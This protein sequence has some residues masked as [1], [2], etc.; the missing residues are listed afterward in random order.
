[1]VFKF[2]M[3]MILKKKKN[4]LKKLNVEHKELIKEILLIINLME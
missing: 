2:I 3:E 1:M 4:K